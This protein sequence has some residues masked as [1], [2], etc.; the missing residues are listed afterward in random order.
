MWERNS[1]DILNFGRQLSILLDHHCQRNELEGNILHCVL[2]RHLLKENG[3][4]MFLTRLLLED[5]DICVAIS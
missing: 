5:I 3:C 1:A 4:G 2:W